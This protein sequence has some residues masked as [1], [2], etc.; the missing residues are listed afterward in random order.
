MS[1]VTVISGSMCGVDMIAASKAAKPVFEMVYLLLFCRHV[2]YPVYAGMHACMHDVDAI[3]STG[4]PKLKLRQLLVQVGCK[5][6]V[7]AQYYSETPII[8]T[9]L[10]PAW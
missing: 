8:R 7:R 1:L 6:I 4:L 3:R 2:V 5:C 9:S 10:C